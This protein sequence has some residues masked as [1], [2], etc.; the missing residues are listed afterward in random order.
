MKV[1]ELLNFNRES[2]KIMRRCGVR[3]N[4]VDYIG[5]FV[6]YRRMVAEGEKVTYVVA[7]LAEKYAISVRQVYVLVKRMNMDCRMDAAG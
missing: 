2:I 4:D 1:F 3:L 6:E 5:L 7:R